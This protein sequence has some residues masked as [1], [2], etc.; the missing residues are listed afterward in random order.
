MADNLLAG[1]IGSSSI[2]TSIENQELVKKGIVFHKFSYFNYEAC[3]VS[4][5]GS[6]PIYL[7]AEQGFTSDF[8]DTKIKS[9]VIL[10]SG[11]N[12]NWIGAFRD[13]TIY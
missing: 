8:H 2:L 4:I 5:N 7:A 1:F 11:V 10:N 9:F 3:T 6:S 12:F 13:A